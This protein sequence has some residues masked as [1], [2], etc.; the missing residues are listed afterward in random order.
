MTVKEPKMRNGLSLA[1][2]VNANP[3]FSQLASAPGAAFRFGRSRIL[4]YNH[5]HDLVFDI[6]PKKGC[7]CT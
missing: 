2:I 1:L 7:F 3:G 4:R 5:A 6:P